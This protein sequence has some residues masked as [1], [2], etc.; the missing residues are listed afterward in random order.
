MAFITWVRRSTMITL[1]LLCSRNTAVARQSGIVV[2]SGS[3]ANLSQ[4]ADTLAREEMK[5]ENIAGLSLAIVVDKKIVVSRAYGLA[6]VENHAPASTATLFRTGSI[7]KPITAAA[8]MELY[9]Q[10]KL[11]LDAPVQTYCPRFPRKQWTITTRELLGHLS[12]IRHYQSDDS[13]FFS[14]KHYAHV[15]DGFEI[16]AND[17]LLFEPGTRMEYSTYGYSVVGCVIEGASHEE[18]MR[19]LSEL[20]IAPATMQSTRVDDVFQIIDGRS[21]PY[22]ADKDRS[23]RNATFV[24]TSNKIPGGGLISTAEDL[25]RFSIAL[26][27]NTF[28]N[29][30]IT[31]LMWTSQTTTDGKPTGYGYGWDVKQRNGILTVEH[32]GHQPGASNI[33]LLLPGRGFA[34]AIMSNTDDINVTPMAETL[35]NT[36]LNAG[37]A[38][39]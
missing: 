14:T 6:D 12:G 1:V 10:G 9:Q 39:Q 5:K 28:L 26:E 33:L 22:T 4:M 31:K 11:D 36:Y 18:F 8:A 13:D 15:S 17:P 35:A 37:A 21:R 29:A 20:V 25:A 30:E 7:A 38:R 27:S 23:L 3:S 2:A 16:F 24:D 19:A 32:T 34:V